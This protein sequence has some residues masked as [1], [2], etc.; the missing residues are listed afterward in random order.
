[1]TDMSLLLDFVEETREHLE[2]MESCLLRLEGDFGEDLLN[3]VFRSVH[4]IKGASEYLGLGHIAE[5]SHR[6]ESLLDLLRRG[7]TK[8]SAPVVDL[9]MDARDII[10]ELC[11]GAEKGD[12][13]SV[14]IRSILERIENA[15]SETVDAQDKD[16][17]EKKDAVIIDEEA[18]EELFN[19]FLKQLQNGLCALLDEGELY[20]ESKNSDGVLARCVDELGSLESSANYMGYDAL[21]DLYREWTDQVQKAF[22]DGVLEIDPDPAEFAD[23]CIIKNIEKLRVL[24]PGANNFSDVDEKIDVL[25]AVVEKSAGDLPEEKDELL[26]FSFNEGDV[27]DENSNEGTL[28]SDD[29]EEELEF[30]LLLEEDAVAEDD[31]ENLVDPLLL[32]FIE[33]TREHLE[34]MESCLLKLENDF[35]QTLLNDLFRSVHTIKGASEYL[36]LGRI[37]ELTHRL[38]SLLDLLRSGE[39][40]AGPTVFDVLMDAKDIIISLCNDAEKGEFDAVQTRDILDRIE[41]ASKED[42]P[43]PEVPVEEPIEDVIVD[44]EADEELFDIFL[45]QQC[46]G[47]S[48]LLDAVATDHTD[49]DVK[50]LA[51]QCIEAID[52]LGSSANYMGYDTLVDMYN[53]WSSAVEEISPPGNNDILLNTDEFKDQFIRPYIEKIKQLF[54]DA[55][56]FQELNIPEKDDLKKSDESITLPDVSQLLGKIED[57]EG[58]GDETDLLGKLGSAFDNSLGTINRVVPESLNGEVE[59]ELLLG[60]NMDAASE[61]DEG[62]EGE[63][64]KE[65]S[66]DDAAASDIL[67]Q[68]SQKTDKQENIQEIYDVDEYETDDSEEDEYKTQMPE[69]DDSHLFEA[70]S[71]DS[72]LDDTRVPEHEDRIEADAVL[73][74]EDEKR[75][76]FSTVDENDVVP[77]D[78]RPRQSIRVEASKIDDLMNQVGELVVSRA[79]FSQLFNEMRDLQQ[80]LKQSFRLDQK[81]LKKVSAIT[82]HLNEATSALARTA[83]DLQ[84]GVMKV[85]MLPIARLFS[86][87]P[88]LV[89][90]LV[91]ESNKK[92]RLE[93]RGEDTEL[94]R[95]VIEKISD[96]LIHVIRNAVDHGIEDVD[97]REKI[98][99]SPTAVLGLEAYH[100][101]NL[102]VIEITDD[103]RGIDPENIRQ[104][105]LENK[106]VTEEEL[107]VLTEKQVIELVMQPGFSTAAEVTHTS[108]RGVGMDVVKKN[109][110]KLN[111]S[112]EIETRKDSG[113]RLIIKIPLTLAIIPALLVKGGPDTFLLPMASV[114]ETIR[115]Y[116]AEILT[117]E[118]VEVIHLRDET[119]PLIRLAETFSIHEKRAD[120]DRVFVVVVSAGSKKA[121]IVVDAMLG[122]EEVVIK[123]LEDYIQE[124]SGFSGATILGDG[125]IAL[126]LDVYDLVNLAI[127]KQAA[128]KMEEALF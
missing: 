23:A 73:D 1:M 97:Q 120:E 112:V 41:A 89:R 9:L 98:G 119:I 94:D 99:K 47:L 72:Q 68:F 127:E 115:V 95:M 75:V 67:E 39:K 60:N 55:A 36:G 121:G 5:L 27:L 96:P 105:A 79:W 10:G 19:I 51:S 25:C 87:Y 53:Q 62:T 34:D 52:Q 4:T 84:E 64:V 118:G 124:D 15:S 14:D 24:F 32:D 33:E 28:E 74:M 102:V 49:G 59:T 116:S 50:S 117:I 2:D 57:V 61:Y 26:N 29:P 65:P 111:G 8:A 69:Y 78:N 113:T 54:P 128:K 92:V 12:Y 6:L 20:W 48:E 16:A 17:Q 93:V 63:D 22:G 88:R 82:S 126:I 66:E 109:I 35:S 110:E 44:E 37:A 43:E 38:E 104:K 80:H 101:G 40:E 86:R 90:D 100:E 81:E 70:V 11:T 77:Q 108:G 45:T 46:T 18:D 76:Q 56:I 58:S 107:N 103:G 123:P 31:D 106:F 42:D 30:S 13:E 125:S 71:D 21:V 3:D 122:R 114:D 7:E 85:R 91:R 83:N